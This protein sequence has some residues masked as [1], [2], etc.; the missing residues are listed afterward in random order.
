MGASSGDESGGE[1]W[2]AGLFVLRLR[3]RY[4]QDERMKGAVRSRAREAGIR[5]VDTLFLPPVFPRGLALECST[6]FERK[7]GVRP[8]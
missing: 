3:W 4:A 6:G 1:P 7:T 5:M 8:R 2:A